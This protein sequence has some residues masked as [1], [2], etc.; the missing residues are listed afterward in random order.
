[1]SKSF[2]GVQDPSS[3]NHTDDQEKPK[4]KSYKVYFEELIFRSS[5][6]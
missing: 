3:G 1:M 6:W 5:R 4:S 2:F